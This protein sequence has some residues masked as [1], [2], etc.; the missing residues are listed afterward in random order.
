MTDQNNDFPDAVGNIADGF[1]TARDTLRAAVGAAEVPAYAK[2]GNMTTALQAGKHA[3]AGEYENVAQDIGVAALQTAMG[4]AAGAVGA[5]AIAAGSPVILTGLAVAGAV[6]YAG[7]GW[8]EIIDLIQENPQWLDPLFP[9]PNSSNPNN[10]NPPS[11]DY[12]IEYYDPLILDLNGDGEIGTIAAN[13]FQGA[14]FD[15][16]NDGIKTATGWVSPEDGLLVR[17]INSDGTI[18]SGAELFG[19]STKL[20]NGTNAK[21][22]FAALS[23]LDSNGDGKVDSN[24]ASFNE[25]KIWKDINGDGVS[26][27][28][29]LFSLNGVGIQSLNV[30]INEIKNE[31]VEGGYLAETGSYTKADGSL[32]K[33]A[34]VNFENQDIYSKFTSQV[35]VTQDVSVLPQLK[36]YGRLQDLHQV[37]MQSTEFKN[38]LSQ[39]VNATTRSQQKE[40]LD[41]LVKS[42]AKSDP[43]YS[44][45]PI[46]IIRLINVEW[47]QSSNSENV[48][49]V[50]R[51]DPV[52][53]Y[54]TTPPPPPEIADAN[55]TAKVRFVDAFLGRE[56]TTQLNQYLADQISSVEQIY[57]FVKESIFSDL[58]NQTILKPYLDSVDMYLGLEEDEVYFD[59]SNLEQIFSQKIILSPLAA[60]EDLK[61]LL[62]INGNFLDIAGWE[63]GF[64]LLQQW[65]DDFSNDPALK[66]LID[67]VFAD[68]DTPSTNGTNGN[69]FSVI[70]NSANTIFDAGSGDDIVIIDTDIGITVNGDSGNDIIVSGKNN[71]FLNGGEGNNTYILFKGAGKDFVN[72]ENLST[73]TDK[74]AFTDVISTEATFFQQG[75]NLVIK[76]GTDEVTLLGALDSTSI[77]N[78]SF[79]FKDQVFSLTTIL[80]S[81][82]QNIS[83]SSDELYINGWR[84]VD[85]LTGNDLGNQIYGFDGNDTLIGKKGSDRL[86][87]GSG[88]DTYHFE[89]G[90]GIDEIHELDYSLEEN[91]VVFQ[92]IYTSDISNITFQDSDLIIQYGLTDT[93]VLKNYILNSQNSALKIQFADQAIWNNSDLMSRVTFEGSDNSEVIVGTL[94]NRLNI[95]NAY[96]GNDEV[97]GNL[98][99]QNLIDGGLGDDRLHGGNEIDHIQGGFGDDFIFGLAGNDEIHGGEGDDTL[100]GGAGDDLIIGG[101]GRDWLQGDEGANILIGGL[102]DDSYDVNGTDTIIENE[103]EGY[104]AIFIENNF[105]L[106]GTNLEEIHLKGSG[107]FNAIGDAKE[108]GLYGNS[109]NNYL[110]GKGGA[111]IMSGGAGDDYYVVNQYDKLITNSDGTTTLI[112]GDQVVEGI[113]N[114]A[115]YVFGDSGGIDTIE[116]WDDKRFYSQDSNGNWFDTGN[117]HNLQSNVENVILKGDAKVAFGNELDNIITGNEQDNFI[118]G[119]AGDDTYIYKKGGGTDTFSFED[120]LSAVNIL[121]IEGH[122]AN[123]LYA[124]KFGESVLI[125]FRNSTDKIWLSNYNLADYQDSE[126]TTFSN[127]FDQI[128]FDSGEIWT[129]SEI[130]S[131][132]LRAENNQAPVIQQY[133]STLN[134]KIE[135]VLQYTFSNI[136][137]DP[138]ADDQLSFKLTLQT[139]DA[140][141]DYQD[142]PEWII[143]DPLTLT[144]TVSPPEGVD[145]GQLNFYLWG[146]D[147][148]G[149]GTG[150][151]VNINIQP[152]ANTPIPGAIYDTLGNDSLI[153]GDED[154]IFF[155]TGGKDVLQEVGGIDVL[156]FS[157]G[158]TFN[159]VGSGLMKSGNDLI[160]KVNGSSANQVT[161]KNYFLAGN[162]LVETIDFETG[163]QLT[164]EQ[165]FGAFGLTIPTTGGGTQPANPVGDTIYSYTAGELTINEQSGT[166]KVIF[167]NGI[168]FS[169]VGNYLSKSGDDL[170]LKINGSN[171][172]KVT[173]KNFFLAGN[174][175]VENFEFETGG[176]LTAQQ[177]FDAFGLTL[178]STGGSGNQGS[179]EVVGDTTYNYTSGA[180]TI[181]EQSGNDKVIFKNGITFN[182]VGSYLTKSGDDLILKVNGS[183]TNKVTVK[184]FFLAGEYLV[185]TFQ[186]ETGGQ[187]TAEQIFGAFGI[188]MPQQSAPANIPPENI[189]S[190]A[191][192]TIYNY[193][194]GVMVIDEKLGTDQALFGNDI[195][196][197]QVGNYLTKSGDDLILKVNGSNS[198]KITVKDFF[199]GG[200]HEVESFN[201]ETGGSISSQQIYQVF[202]VDRP[203]NA[204][205][206]VTS[207]VMGDSGNNILSSDAAVS[208]LFVLNE[209]NDILEL[210]LNASGETPVDFVTDFD[211]T[212][213]QIDLSQILDNHANSSNLSDYI[214]II[215]DANAKTNTLSARNQPTELSKDLL[216]FTNQADSL[217]I[218]DL[219]MNQSIIY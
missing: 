108:N 85:L 194:S 195:A 207:I 200:A 144:I 114:P 86:Y 130:D 171:T 72:Y 166:D 62:E 181:T 124:Q 110:D 47:Y 185:E 26:Q 34:D 8:N 125:G 121:K 79:R 157:N 164:A 49:Y 134:V 21:N 13:K 168:T 68:V 155:Y 109:G 78:I 67:Q 216:I 187:I 66:L 210:L 105:D 180:L 75:H 38:L 116:Q 191:F 205:D 163:G 1:D 42:W 142:I 54:L 40:L 48:I 24:D 36:G 44:N 98:V 60:I 35:E 103:D 96:D 218:A 177:I 111:D 71:D 25:L 174:S 33:M 94:N 128:V 107:D 63:K 18:N 122:E 173:V 215:Y 39:Y 76:Y 176:A 118:N 188:T 186:F 211:M 156:R 148:Y 80:E 100:F 51:G 93:I 7:E 37:A 117:Y 127:K 145:V 219:T 132:L 149:V 203:V 140:S 201:F 160:L 82:L 12:R 161:L 99:A 45:D 137:T 73:G 17:D 158:I 29:E 138:D 87:G 81:P 64:V 213:D 61:D 129:T 52:P 126:N 101:N 189:D 143:F 53:T 179:S 217:S 19:D 20:A 77:K 69:D 28:S 89:L 123:S 151:G 182:Q 175:L 88:N 106:E 196:F 16:D 178:P 15:G 46:E 209:G 5:T 11:R 9:D 22:G 10:G 83:D 90:D 30:N 112:R 150:V 153:G 136:I 135:E 57:D 120:E 197:S 55:L 133:P 119:L 27:A 169:Q 214:E 43:A 102:G 131:L 50:R 58:L 4:I 31:Q 184:N 212:E 56:P 162:N 141:G 152:S 167:K 23:D 74:I 115:G 190:D 2:L 170:V 95:I 113:L 199:L 59:F 6:W 154:N 65:R 165:I 139:Q 206:E 202:G 183:N 97:R 204:E 208:E 91:K 104:D 41:S 193:S 192:N 3:M 32:G 70:G 172:N 147:L 146:T 14:V 159:Q 84:G 198:D 92:N